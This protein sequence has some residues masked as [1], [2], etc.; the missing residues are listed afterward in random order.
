M[1]F[2]SLCV[3]PFQAG[4]RAAAPHLLSALSTISELLRQ[5]PGSLPEAF[6]DDVASS[7]GGKALLKALGAASED[8]GQTQSAVGATSKGNGRTQS[9][10]G[11]ALVECL[12]AVAGVIVPYC[13]VRLF[14]VGPTNL[15]WKMVGLLAVTGLLLRT[16]LVR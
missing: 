1:D 7:Q 15:I 13:E 6:F 4:S 3:A 8:S 5:L 9:A 11:T 14:R 16:P 12:L 10:V 2:Q